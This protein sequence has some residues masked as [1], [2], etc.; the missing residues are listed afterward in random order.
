MKKNKNYKQSKNL[1][2][3]FNC[4]T[5]ECHF[6]TD[7]LYYRKAI[8]I[9]RDKKRKPIIIMMSLCP[10]CSTPAIC[11]EDEEKKMKAI[12]DEIKG[13][14]KMPNKDKKKIRQI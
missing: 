14:K 7:E 11:G 4:R 2:M 13:I 5:C 6:K 9:T 12:L 8:T 10:L 1:V 3:T